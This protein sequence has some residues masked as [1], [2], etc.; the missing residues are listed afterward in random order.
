MSLNIPTINTRILEIQNTLKQKNEEE[1]ILI[2]EL[3]ILWQ[4]QRELMFGVT[5]AKDE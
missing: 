5:A 1:R 2:E 3:A 4:K